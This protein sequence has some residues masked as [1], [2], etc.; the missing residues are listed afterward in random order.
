MK[1]CQRREYSASEKKEK[2]NGGCKQQ[3]FTKTH[4]KANY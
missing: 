1:I 3:H 2:N 4:K